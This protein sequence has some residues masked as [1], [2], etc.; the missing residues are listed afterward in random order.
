LY[1]QRERNSVLTR[2]AVGTP[3]ADPEQIDLG[4]PIWRPELRNPRDH[5]S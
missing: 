5:T 4:R 3:L 2:L 1:A